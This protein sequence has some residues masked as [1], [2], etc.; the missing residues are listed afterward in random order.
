MLRILGC[1]T[2]DHD[3]RLVA[4]AGFLCLAACFAAVGMVTRANASKG[5]WHYLWVTST[6]FVVGGAIWSTHFVAMLGFRP[7]VPVS[8][9]L[10][11]T[12]TSIILSI[13]LATA[14]VAIALRPR[15]AIPGGMMLGVAVLAMHYVGMSALNVPGTLHW[16]PAYIYA[17]VI[18][19]L[20][21][22]ALAARYAIE[23]TSWSLRMLGGVFG[24]LAICGTH[25]TSMAGVTISFDPTVAM[26]S[27]SIEPVW[28]AISI[29]TITTIIIA[30]ALLGV[31]LDHHLTRRSVIEASRLRAHVV[32][33]EA[34]KRKLEATTADML[35]ALEAA[36]T[37][38]QSKS[39]F[40]AT[41]SHELRTPLNAIIGFSEI[42]ATELF[43]PLGNP[44]Y[45]EYA[46][47]VKDSGSH[48][49]S[50]IND[51]LD[52]SK[53]DAGHLQ[54]DD[55]NVALD[56]VIEES[57][58]MVR[59]QASHQE[60]NLSTEIAGNLPLVL[61]DH[62]RVRQV[63]LNLLS[64]ATKFT[65]TGGRITVS[66]HY[67]G[68]CV[69]VSVADTGIG[70]A[71][72]DIPLAMERFGQIDSSLNRKYEGTGLGLPLSKRL[73]ELHDGTLTLESEL[74]VGTTVTALFPAHRTVAR[75]AVA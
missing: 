12:F 55:E 5:H 40:L 33:L 43:G 8:Y 45:K 31:I 59:Q 38:N 20:V 34:T 62:R 14:G 30:L 70:I 39:Q 66:A 74:N 9:S 10:L 3:L 23:K 24:T 27:T 64:N 67:D 51:I 47:D 18:C 36:S 71:A 65:P 6:G 54:L 52:F 50:L 46:N 61:C 75:K 11:P 17:S 68:E 49:L 25:F 1:I 32:E 56:Q 42:L 16:D 28:L 41:M 7:E 44:R 48:L 2:Q 57:I 35:K 22:G 37:S 72:K 15:G 53:V 60:V 73:I 26:P 58:R 13:V 4:L 69:S 19:G 29:F 21:F 63:L